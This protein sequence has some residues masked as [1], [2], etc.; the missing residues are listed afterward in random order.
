MSEIVVRDGTSPQD[1]IHSKLKE[2]EMSLEN[3]CKNSLFRVANDLSEDG[4]AVEAGTYYALKGIISGLSP[5]TFNELNQALSMQD[6]GVLL[7]ALKRDIPELEAEVHLGWPVDEL[8]LDSS[9][10]QSFLDAA[11]LVREALESAIDKEVDDTVHSQGLEVGYSLA[12]SVHRIQCQ[13]ML[14]R[15]DEHEH[16]LN[17]LYRKIG[18]LKPGSPAGF[19]EVRTLLSSQDQQLL[20]QTLR[21]EEEL[22]KEDIKN[23]PEV[24]L[25]CEG[26]TGEADLRRHH[27]ASKKLMEGLCTI[28][29]RREF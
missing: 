20:L 16:A 22:L 15:E 19:H 29:V 5:V 14:M 13:H 27:L 23:A 9:D 6:K 11:N 3:T 24:P 12:A 2:L 18:E 1:E 21:E 8:D 17:E 10:Y 28:G 7:D 25:W 26:E 4:K